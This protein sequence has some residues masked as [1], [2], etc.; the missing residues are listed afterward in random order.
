MTRTLRNDLF[1]PSDCAIE[2]MNTNK[3]KIGEFSRLCRVTVRT[4][5]HYQEIGLFEPEIIDEWTGY[6]YYSVGQFQKMQSIKMLKELGFSLEEIRELYEDDTHYPSAKAL[7]EKIR[8]CELELQRLK[9]R[10]AQLK[11]MLKFQKKKQK[12]KNITIEKLPAFIA[13]T[14]RTKIESYECLGRVCCE[15][16]APEMMRLGCQCPEPGYCYSIEYGGYRPKDIDIEYVERVLEKGT[17][18]S[19]IKFKEIPEVPTAVCMKVY[20]PYDRLY[21]AYQDVFAWIEKEG[22]QIVGNP[23]A[24][25]VDG[26]WNEENPEKWLTI[27]QV[28]V[29]KV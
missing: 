13:A 6:R 21:Q 11:E 14:H 23:R 12:M 22:Y 24:N 8:V 27:I 18:S 15:V 20:G 26:I 2:K 7:E 4:L 9:E 28:P 19:I 10:N 3:I 16:I 25:Y 1:L 29:A 5:R 17:D